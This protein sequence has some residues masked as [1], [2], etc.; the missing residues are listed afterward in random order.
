MLIQFSHEKSWKNPETWS[1]S[2]AE[3][4]GFSGA[5]S[6]VLGKLTPK[7]GSLH[8]RNLTVDPTWRIPPMGLPQSNSHHS[9]ERK[10]ISPWRGTVHG[11]WR[12]MLEG[13]QLDTLSSHG[14]RW[15]LD[16]KQKPG[17]NTTQMK[18]ACL[19]KT[20]QTSLTSL[21]CLCG[22]GSIYWLPQLSWGSCNPE[23]NS[24]HRHIK[25]IL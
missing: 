10:E 9:G 3:L 25:P 15:K 16:L 24:K 23:W 13:F 11:Q 19:G 14:D 5:S 22:Y 1:I 20:V 17:E 6:G 18:M 2:W 4:E 7:A 12:Q 21:R 8:C